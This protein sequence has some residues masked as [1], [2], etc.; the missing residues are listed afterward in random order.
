MPNHKK[1][2][3]IIFIFSYRAPDNIMSTIENS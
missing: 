3:I 1:V 2:T